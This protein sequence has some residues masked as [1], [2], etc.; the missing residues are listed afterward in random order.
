MI[1]T[2]E[3]MKGVRTLLQLYALLFVLT[4]ITIMMLPCRIGLQLLVGALAVFLAD[5]PVYRW[6]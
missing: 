6:I 2:D 1:Q 5:A 4:H 3:C